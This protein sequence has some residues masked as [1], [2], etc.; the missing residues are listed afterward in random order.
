MPRPIFHH[1]QGLCGAA[2]R[3]AETLDQGLGAVE[4]RHRAFTSC[5]QE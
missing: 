5:N 1:L 3:G 4:D 2:R